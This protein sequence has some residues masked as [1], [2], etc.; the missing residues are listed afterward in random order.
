VVSVNSTRFDDLTI[1]VSGDLTRDC[2]IN[3]Q[4]LIGTSDCIAK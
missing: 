4:A 1:L 3:V 2:K